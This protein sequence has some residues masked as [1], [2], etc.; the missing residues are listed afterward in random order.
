MRPDHHDWS[1][2]ALRRICF[3]EAHR[4]LRDPHDADDAAQEAAIR[5]WRR[6]FTCRRS[7]DPGPWVRQIAR[8]EALRVAARRRAS[9][10]EEQEVPATCAQPADEVHDRLDVRRALDT[11]RADDRLVLRARYELDLEQRT[12]ADALGI[13][14]GTAKVRLHRARVRLRHALS[15]A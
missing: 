4:L 11:L 7:D 1:W 10:L 13:P 3:Q 9:A 2:P 5:A 6:R 12:I 15:S 14:E 8:R